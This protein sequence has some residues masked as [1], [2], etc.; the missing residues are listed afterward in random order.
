MGPTLAL[1]RHVN[2]LPTMDPRWSYKSL[3]GQREAQRWQLVGML[4]LLG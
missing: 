2:Q 1:G 4:A 3:D